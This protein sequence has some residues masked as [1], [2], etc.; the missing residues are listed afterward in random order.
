M[1][2]PFYELTL[3]V[4]RTTNVDMHLEFRLFNALFNYFDV[5]E[6]IIRNNAC[7]SKTLV[8]KACELAFTKLAKYYSKTKSKDKLIYNLAIILDF[9]QKLNLYRD[10]NTK[11]V[12]EQNFNKIGHSY[13]NKYKKEFKNYFSRH[14]EERI[15]TSRVKTQ[16]ASEIDKIMQISNAIVYLLIII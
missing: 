12:E 4:S 8:I 15:T 3:I 13:H 7:S 5:V 10:W 6:R 16:R 11:N 1:L 14:Y 2:C 9:T